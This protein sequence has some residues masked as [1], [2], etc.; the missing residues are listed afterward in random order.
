M[1]PVCPTAG[2]FGGWIGGYFGINSPPHSKGKI[3]SALITANLIA[4]T[5]IALKIIFHISLCV[6][7]E[8][9]QANIARVVIK[10]FLMGI[11]YSIGVNYLLN[12][13]VFLSQNE[14]KTNLSN[15][16]GDNKGDNIEDKSN[17][18]SCCCK[19]KQT[20]IMKNKT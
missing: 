4:I 15:S 2:W 1:C 7:G 11:I 5:V 9:S 14:P 17:D 3:V 8:F 13:Y 18:S 16:Q 19:Q 10:T 20:K 12:R 6:G